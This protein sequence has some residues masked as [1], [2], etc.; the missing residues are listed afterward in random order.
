M[1]MVQNLSDRAVQQQKEREAFRQQMKNQANQDKE[2][3]R[4]ALNEKHDEEM[5]AL[6]DEL[7]A[8]SNEMAEQVPGD[9]VRSGE[10]TELIHKRTSGK[11]AQQRLER[12]NKKQKNPDFWKKALEGVGKI[13]PVPW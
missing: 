8:K 3:L 12:D 13:V 7:N 11:E 2:D 1:K 6:R 9:E 10:T 4:K 5:K